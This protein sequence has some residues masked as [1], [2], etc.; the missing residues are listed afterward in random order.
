MKLSK[1]FF[2][3]L[4]TEFAIQRENL[5]SFQAQNFQFPEL[6]ENTKASRFYKNKTSTKQYPSKENTENV[7]ELD[8]EDIPIDITYS[9]DQILEKLQSLNITFAK[10][11]STERLKKTFVTKLKQNHPIN[12]Y[13]KMIENSKLKE[14]VEKIGI[15]YNF[16]RDK[17]CVTIANFFSILIQAHL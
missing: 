17:L 5:L 3:S 2:E 6:F 10:N 15:S 13:L 1:D 4:S 7:K 12:Q 9:R 11:N 16:R 14:I 8:P